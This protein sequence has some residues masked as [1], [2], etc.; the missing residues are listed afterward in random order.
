MSL[1]TK[2]LTPLL[3]Y[4][5]KP[6]AGEPAGLTFQPAEAWDFRLQVEVPCGHCM[7]CQYGLV[8]E[9]TTRGIQEAYVS[10]VSLFVTLT[11][12]EESVRKTPEGVLTLC[13]EDQTLF[14][15]RLRE[16]L[17]GSARG[18]LRVTSV[19]EYGERSLRPHGHLNLF[20]GY[21]LR[22]VLEGAAPGRRSGKTGTQQYLSPLMS[23][24]WPYGEVLVGLLTPGGVHYQSLHRSKQ[25]VFPKG[26]DGKLAPGCEA[27]W[28]QYPQ[29]PALGDVYF[30]RFGVQDSKQGFHV[31]PGGRK[32]GL[33]RRHLELLRR[34][35]PDLADLVRGKRLRFARSVKDADASYAE[36]SVRRDALH[37]LSLERLK[38]W[39]RKGV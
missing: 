33:T 29:R 38:R 14:V 11:Y 28:F 2:C 21:L 34:S 25:H 22:K 15:K 35:D 8:L 6:R 37:R 18:D 26:P 13:R 12:S 39:E 24:L 16:S 20:G 9:T 7:H 31:L 23:R 27:P 32:R 17:F 3:M 1:Q 4:P 19:G 5:A 10:A 36:M 30:E